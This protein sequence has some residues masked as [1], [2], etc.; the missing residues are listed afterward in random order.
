MEIL[1]NLGLPILGLA[2]FWVIAR[3]LLDRYSSTI[4]QFLISKPF[5][6]IGDY[7]DSAIDKLRDKGDKET[8]KKVRKLAVDAM[9]SMAKTFEQ[10]LYDGD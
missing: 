1:K 3:F 7:V 9:N 4:I 5:T 2:L 6:W 10:K 8:A